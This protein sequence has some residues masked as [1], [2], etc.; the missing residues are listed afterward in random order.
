MVLKKRFTSLIKRTNSHE[1]PVADNVDTPEANA[2][3]GVRLFCE[4]GAANLGEEV[5]HLPVIV[6][7]AVA[8]P[9]A[10]QAAAN[11][12]RKF[13]SKENYDR[14]HVQYNAVMLIR[15]LADNPGASFT[16]NIDKQFAD[17][18][19]Q[20][21]RNGRDPSVS[22]IL[23]ETLDSIHR[24]KAYDANLNTLFA[25]WTKEKKL[26]AD[27]A[28]HV[29]RG[30][31]TQAPR[32]PDPNLPQ[33][34]NSGHRGG[35]LPPPVELAARI[36]E[37]RTSA[38][39]LLQLVQSTPAN[40]LLGN[41]LVKEF[42]ERCTSAQRSVQTYIN[43]D[44]PPPDDDTMLT[45]IETN[46]QL[47]LAA[48]KHQRAV[49]QARRAIG[50][51]PSPPVPSNTYNNINNNYSALPP[52]PAPA[53]TY[54]TPPVQQSAPQ[55]EIPILPPLGLEASEPKSNNLASYKKDGLPL[56]PAL[57]AGPGRPRSNSNSAQD[58]EDNPFADHHTY[59]APAGPPPGQTG[60]SAPANGYTPYRQGYQPTPSYLGRQESAANNVTMHGAGHSNLSEE[61]EYA[62]GY[63]ASNRPKTPEESHQRHGSDVSPLT[64]RGTVTYRY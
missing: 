21:L 54:N 49:L 50:A 58:T 38:K 15:I 12:I 3:R 1:E 34:F 14:P 63:P 18:V 31:I 9:Q 10:A 48:S 20:L 53:T 61:E 35:G 46:E 28:K 55:S 30:G 36:E 40:E 11:Q 47:S 27:A 52:V 39:L 7:S 60:E 19:K 32:W 41:E 45:L 22:Q 37:A 24:D 13:L 57:Q 23:R 4:S 42:A 56:P 26:M 29:P 59:S 16:K 64:D 44:N 17:T 51:A 6:E 62:R 5:L 25:M 43:Y 2:A 8:S 33:G